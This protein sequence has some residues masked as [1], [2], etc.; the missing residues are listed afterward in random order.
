MGANLCRMFAGRLRRTSILF[1]DATFESL[2]ARLARQLLYLGRREGRRTE[3]G[4]QLAGRFRQG[5]LADLLGATTRSIITILNSWR[6]DGLVIYDAARAQ[7]TLCRED[8]LQRLIS[9]DAT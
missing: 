6:A 7:L 5:D 1:R 8:D 4:L 2:D 9:S 3:Q